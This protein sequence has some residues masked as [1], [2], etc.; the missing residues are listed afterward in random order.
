S[1]LTVVR[2]DAHGDVVVLAGAVALAGQLAHPR[3]Q[4]GEQVRLPARELAL[5]HRG[6]ALEP[7]AG[8][9]GRLGQRRHAP[10]GVAVELHENQV[11]ELQPPVAL[12]GRALAGPAR[13]HLRARQM[14][15]LVE[16]DLRARA[17][18]PRVAHGPEV[19]LLTQPQDALIGEPGDLLPE[20]E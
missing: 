11:P 8:V 12:A 7:H 3:D 10:A 9:D 6:D 15:A 2:D 5:H 14:V 20:G 19:V 17:A 16:V 1:D 18:R 13:F 4:R